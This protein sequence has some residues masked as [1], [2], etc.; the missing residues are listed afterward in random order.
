MITRKDMRKVAKQSN[1]DFYLPFGHVLGRE[2]GL[3]CWAAADALRGLGP[4]PDNALH[5]QLIILMIGEMAETGD[6]P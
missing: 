2:K 5:A 1:A 3:A 6:L 4:W